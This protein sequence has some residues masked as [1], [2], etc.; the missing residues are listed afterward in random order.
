MF[1]SKAN[2]ITTA[3]KAEKSSVPCLL[4]NDDGSQV[5]RFILPVSETTEAWSNSFEEIL[6]YK[7]YTIL[8]FKGRNSDKF[9]F[10]AILTTRCRSRSIQPLIDQ[11]KALMIPRIAGNPKLKDQLNPDLLTLVIGDVSYF[12]LYLESAEVSVKERLNGHPIL[13]EVNLSFISSFIRVRSVQ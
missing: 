8:D 11:L 13:A 5:F 4:S 6:P 3:L 1:D 10:Q 2:S 7:K 12:N 9:S